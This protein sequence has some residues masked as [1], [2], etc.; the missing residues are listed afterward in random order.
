[1]GKALSQDLLTGFV[2]ID[3][4]H[5]D[6]HERIDQ[7]L[8]LLAEGA[9]S[10][11]LASAFEFLEEFSEVH[12]SFEETAMNMYQYPERKAHI[13]EHTEMLTNIRFLR[14][15]VLS[16]GATKDLIQRTRELLVDDLLQHIYEYD[17]ELAT[18]LREKN[19]GKWLL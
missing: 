4:Q 6:L 13:A 15:E 2:L 5:E 12:F 19:I 18:F 17:A 11:L 9:G 7:L 16:C 3:R 1:M 8:G 14:A 10:S